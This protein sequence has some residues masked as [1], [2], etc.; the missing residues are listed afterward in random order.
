MSWPEAVA[1]G[2]GVWRDEQVGSFPE[3]V[4]GGERFGVGDVERGAGDFFLLKSGDERGLIEQGAPR[5]I[6]EASRGLHAS[7]LGRADEV[8]RLAGFRRADDNEI[9]LGQDIM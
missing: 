8:H 5:D 1:D 4:G 9:G 2:A 3:W 7:K 6:D